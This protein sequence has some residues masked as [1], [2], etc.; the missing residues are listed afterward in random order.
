MTRNQ[1]GPSG[2]NSASMTKR[3]S[4]RSAF[5]ATQQV[6]ED[7][8]VIA[9]DFGTTFSGVAT[10]YSATPDEVDIIRTWP[11]ITSRV[12]C[13]QSATAN[14][15]LKAVMESPATKSLQRYLTNWM[16]TPSHS[17][18]S[19]RSRTQYLEQKQQSAGDLCTSQRSFGSS[20]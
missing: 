6:V 17:R 15:A 10:V 12:P 8:I 7:K 19:L 2:S 5:A 9:V 13:K 4:A 14:F 3:D 16:P 1:Q 11:G 20:A 18:M